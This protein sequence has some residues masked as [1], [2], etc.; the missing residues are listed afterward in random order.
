MYNSQF[1]EYTRPYDGIP[2]LAGRDRAGRG[3]RRA[4]E[5]TARAA[6]G[7]LDGLGLSR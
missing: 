5:Q 7:V 6:R 1:V 2:E 3:S 4:H